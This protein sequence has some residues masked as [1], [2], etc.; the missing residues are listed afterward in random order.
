MAKLI[1]LENLSRFKQN[2]D[3]LLAN[4]MDKLNPVSRGTFSHNRE[5]TSIT[6]PDSIVLGQGSDDTYVYNNVTLTFES[7]DTSEHTATFVAA[8]YVDIYGFN[9]VLEFTD[10][11]N[12]YELAMVSSTMISSN[13]AHYRLVL[14]NPQ[15]TYT[16]DTEL[17]YTAIKQDYSTKS[18][19]SGNTSIVIGKK[20]KATNFNDVCIGSGNTA[21]GG[22]SVAIGVYNKST[23]YASTTLGESNTASGSYSAAVCYGNT[24]TGGYAFAEGYANTVNGYYGH[25][26]GQQNTINAGKPYAHVEGYDNTVDASGAHAEGR[27]NTITGYGDSHAEGCGN[28]VSGYCGHAEGNSNTASGQY[29]H[30]EGYKSQ[31]TG[32]EAHAEGDWTVASGQGSHT[33][34]F[35]T[36]ASG[37]ATHA[38]GSGTV[39]SG[40]YAH[41]EGDRAN[42]SGN[43]S[44]AQGQ[45]TVASGT[46]SHAEGWKSK[47]TNNSAHAEGEEGTASG[48]GAHVEGQGTIAASN[49]QHVAG[50]FNIEDDQNVYARI[51]GNGTAD[52][53]RSNVETLDWNGNLTVAGNITDGNGNILADKIEGLTILTYGTSTWN[54]FLTAFRKNMIVYCQVGKRLAF[55]TYASLDGTQIN[56]EFQYYRSIANHNYNNQSDETYI[57]KLFPNNTWETTIRKNS[58]IVKVNNGINGNFNTSTNELTLSLVDSTEKMNK[59]NPVG[60]GSFSM[61]RATGSSEGTNSVTANG[62]IIED[63]RA[64]A[65]TFVSQENNTATFTSTD[66]LKH[67]A[68]IGAVITF[69]DGTNTFVMPWISTTQNGNTRTNILDN[70]EGY[71]FDVNA[72]Y[73]TTKIENNESNTASG[74]NSFAIGA[75]NTASGDYSCV[76]GAKNIASGES[77]FAEGSGTTASGYRSHAEGS[78]SKAQANNS[79]AE[80]NGSTASG[81]NS[82]AEG[83]VSKS[84]GAYSH[85]EGNSTTAKGSSSHA[86]GDHTTADKNAAHAGGSYSEAN[87]VSAFAHGDHVKALSGNQTVFGKY[88]IEDSNDTYEFILGNGTA[89]NNRSNAAT[90]DWNGNLW[91]AGNITDGSGNVLANKMDLPIL[92]QTD[93]TYTLQVVILNG[94]PTFSWV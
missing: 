1:S 57:Y 29:S 48:K 63:T 61:N 80:G 78:N 59:A 64:L 83:N 84:Q 76:T 70:S 77:S 3:T 38:E 50:K 7:Q 74:I 37:N 93:G 62:G 89:N 81:A 56:A 58:T 85:A 49:W 15:N 23:G 40:Q 21:S 51:T 14:S 32:K 92:P 24:V 42:A 66:D 55:L 17:T 36:T 11:T 52:D 45:E 16:F 30:V 69:T 88:N 20:N 9:A 54:D 68:A 10:G 75:G 6:G 53:A 71:V 41:A 87:G 94:E 34:G 44:H 27:R 90:V 86:E 25:A 18:I 46:C 73:T 19:A 8:G 47:A 60:T 22:D 31:A 12:T 43:Y 4:K 35:S 13:P 67:F 72:T 28:T 65:L 82:H 5:S 79:H 26:E 33:E 39:A 2:T 91:V